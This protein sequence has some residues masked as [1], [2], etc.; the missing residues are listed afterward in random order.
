M[1]RLRSLGHDGRGR[2]PTLYIT[3]GRGY[4]PRRCTRTEA[5][6]CTEGGQGRNEYGDNDFDDLFSVHNAEFLKDGAKIIRY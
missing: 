1:I 5:K 4:Y 3:C 2:V 6:S